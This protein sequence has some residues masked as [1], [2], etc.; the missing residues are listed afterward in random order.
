MMDRK[1]IVL[2]VKKS[3]KLTHSFVYIAVQK[4]LI[5]AQSVEKKLDSILYFVQGAGLKYTQVRLRIK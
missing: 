5:D 2:S 1:N 3:W 4:Y